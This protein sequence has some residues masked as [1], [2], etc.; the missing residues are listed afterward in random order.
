MYQSPNFRRTQ[1]LQPA[2]QDKYRTQASTLQELFPAWSNE[3][4]QSVLDEVSGDIGLAVSRISEGHA[5]QWGSV[6]RKKDKKPT[7]SPSLQSKEPSSPRSGE[8]RGARG[9]RGGRGGAGRGGAARGSF[10]RGAHHETNGHLPRRS[11]GTETAV[12]KPE[13]SASTTA[14]PVAAPSKLAEDGA[15]TP[16]EAW[17]HP[18]SEAT[19]NAAPSTQS[20]WG[21]STPT[22]WGGD[23][24]VNGSAA[25]P[26]HAPSAAPQRPASVKVT[27]TPATS[28]MSWAQIARPHE[29]AAPTPSAPVPAST[30]APAIVPAPSTAPLAAPEHSPLLEEAPAEL[31]QQGWEEPTTVQAPTWEDEPPAVL[32]ADTWAA[33]TQRTAEEPKAVEVE[34]HVPEEPAVVPE[35][36]VPSALPPQLQQPPIVESL[37]AV[38]KPITPA[39]HTRP[40]AVAHRSSAKF[41]T[42]DQA[43][44]MPSSNFGTVEKVG[45]Q[46]GS[47]S[48]GG[49]DLDVTTYEPASPE[50]V[51]VRATEPSAFDPQLSSQPSSVP[52]P[53]QL[54]ETPATPII[55]PPTQPSAAPNVFQQALPQQVQQQQHQQQQTQQPTQHVAQPQHSLPP[56]LTQPVVPTQAQIQAQPSLPASGT[57]TS[58]ISQYSQSLPQQSISNHQLPQS[59]AQQ[60]HLPYVQH[61]LPSHF[62]PAQNQAH[63]PSI[64]H[65]QQQQQSLGGASY[66]RQPEAPYFHTPTPPAT[67]AQESPYGAFGQL[68][69]Q[70]IQH[71]GQGSRLTGFGGEYGYTDTQRTFYDSYSGS[72]GFGNHNVLGHDEIKGL[73]GA[74]Q[75]SHGAPGLPPTNSQSSQ[76]LPPSSQTNQAQP[77]AGQGPQQSYPPPLPYYFPYPQNQYYGSPYNSGYTVPQPFV[78]YPTV[79]QAG[80]PGPQSA[81]SPAA[82]QGPG[83]VQPQSP[84]A[85]N[86]YGQQHPSSAYDDLGYQHHSQ[87]SHAQ[88]VGST[89]PQAEYGKSLYGAGGQGMQGFMGLGQS[90]GPSS[91]PPI[92]Q[93]AG[94]ASPETVYKPYGGNVGVKDVGGGVG[95]GQGG[96][97]QPQTRGGVQQP[98][99]A[100]FYGAQRFGAGT[101]AVPQSQQAQQHQPQGQ[102]PQ[103]HMG[104]YPQGG[105]DAGQFYTYQPRQQQYWQ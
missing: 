100:G 91:G 16:A 48:V 62:E 86:L 67:Q 87:H 27:K 26:A 105:S 41:K 43:V 52:A 11:H 31:P 54:Q 99:Q 30:V 21:T 83:A 40:A 34:V 90:N 1:Q 4:L 3:D 13:A 104:G 24:A 89:I 25:H 39:A 96:V 80:P 38:V 103:G 79:F 66:F 22:T 73:P 85:Q 55:S 15:Q 59:Q 75:Q 74:Q 8:F 61:G 94:G 65:A 49:D 14:T 23:T 46:F 53:A 71:Q 97:G 102:V 84:Y 98:A 56:S 50:E 82:K 44:V 28:K 35:H 78:K 37:P 2:V 5:E 47:L 12:S 29:K 51:S 95:V 60:Q 76:Q 63:S 101:S 7:T 68:G 32:A 9:G 77:N 17:E 70:Q 93:R 10:A 18:P 92:G 45:M 33:E 88:S 69:Q 58:S 72:A 20:A 81:P 42:T 57:S 64:P 36:A 6:N 19:T